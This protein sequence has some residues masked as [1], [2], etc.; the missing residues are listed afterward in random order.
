[1]QNNKISIFSDIKNLSGIGEKLSVFLEKLIGSNRIIDL[2][3]HKPTRIE[4]KRFLPP[5]YDVKNGELIITKVKVES[6]FK[7]ANNRQPFKV[8]CFAPSGYLTL[9]FFKVF[10][11][12]IE[13]NFPIGDEVVVSG[14]VQKFNDG[15]QISHPEYVY[16]VNKIDYIPKFEIIYPSIG[17]FS[18]KF[19]RSKIALALQIAPDFP[20]WIDVHLLK[21]KNWKSWKES[22]LELHNPKDL[23]PHL[24]VDDNR[25]RLAFDELLAEQIASTIARK[26]LKSNNGNALRFKNDLRKKLIANLPFE[27][28]NGQKKVL[29]QID[30]DLTSSKK[31]LRLLQGDVG[32]GKTIVALMA[33]LL[34]VENK[35]QAALICPITLLA[36]QH[37]NN[38]AKIAELIGI[39]IALLTSKTTAKNKKKILEDLKNGKIDILIGT[40]SLLE[41]D[42]I[43]KDL[44]VAVIDE[45]HR[46][47][48]LQRMKL[49]EKGEKVDVLLM[50]ATPIP[51]SLMMTFYGNM[52]V[53]ILDEKPKNR[54]EIDT[55]IISQAKEKEVLGAIKRAVENGE[56]IYWIC[57]LIDSAVVDDEGAETQQKNELSDVTTRFTKFQEIFGKE[58]VGLIHGQMKES[59]K[60]KI[61]NEFISG[62][63]QILVA[64]T[65]I[66]VGIDVKDASVIV[67]ENPENFGLSALHQLRGRVGRSDKQS[68]CILFYG[69]KIGENSKKRLQI[70][71][72]TNDGFVIAEED[73]KMRGSGEFVGTKQSGLPEYKMADLNLDLDLMKIA[74]RHAQV[75]LEKNLSDEDKLKIKILLKI[76]NL[77]ECYKIGV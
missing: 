13:K 66:E 31:M 40:H 17:A 43:F 7:P 74:N 68:F 45:Q 71:R 46:F 14:E 44:S 56:K 77:Q 16:P 10:P 1:M 63:I 47:G 12:Y 52:D 69:K 38:F 15:L 57:P 67:I 34:A 8:Q 42:I 6:H 24:R 75:M 41:P 28:T 25:R 58:K 54:L 11:N 50:S 55:R 37:F 53:S 35:K 20:E 3:Y 60:D 2:L 65:V 19:L 59:E 72:Q 27:L 61:M 26:Y 62:E 21:Q 30:E 64:T 23:D 22:I 48:V 49:T 76:F 29:A 39:K 33:M 9:V 18:Q 4:P 32:S 51:R 36:I 70:M 5:L 73:L